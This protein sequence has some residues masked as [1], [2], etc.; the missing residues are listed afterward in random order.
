MD[1][2]PDPPSLIKEVDAAK[3]YVLAVT[4]TP[5]SWNHLQTLLTGCKRIRSAVGLHP[6]LV[7]ERSIEVEEVCAIM[8]RTRYVGE[9]GI[10]G[11]PNLRPSF[12]LQ[13]KVFARILRE[14]AKLGGKILSI[15]S[16][17]AATPVLDALSIEPG[18]GAGVLHWFSGNKKELD[19]AI[20]L[21]C[22]F[23]V[24]PAMLLG[25]KGR[26][27]ISRMPP[28]RVLTET[29][30][31]FAQLNMKP[32]LPT[33]VTVAEEGLASIWG[34]SKAQV[35]QRIFQNLRGLLGEEEKPL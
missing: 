14:S 26:D 29:D 22:W 8:P 15:H 5:K 35:S 30:G 2:F 4:T 10:D 18:F 9:V 17:R 11:S 12:E 24:G 27:L 28:H 3:I 32:L 16:R 33:D 19:R 1:L 13:R 34:I 21:G 23:S 20:E 6:A 31:P 25:T 7:S